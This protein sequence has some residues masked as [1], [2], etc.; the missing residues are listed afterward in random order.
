VTGYIISIVILLA[1]ILIMSGMPG[2]SPSNLI[3]PIVLMAAYIVIVVLIM[4]DRE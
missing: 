4:K 2:I 3:G 1:A